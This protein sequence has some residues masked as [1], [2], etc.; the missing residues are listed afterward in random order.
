MFESVQAL[1]R[2]KQKLKF[3][4]EQHNLDLEQAKAAHDMEEEFQ[5]AMKV[6]VASTEVPNKDKP[7]KLV[8]RK[9]CVVLNSV[10]V[11]V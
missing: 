10:C 5:R 7:V 4:Y 9:R 1:E 11:F 8:L 6:E 3:E 2:Q